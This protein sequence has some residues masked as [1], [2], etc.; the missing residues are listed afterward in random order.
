MTSSVRGSRILAL[1]IALVAAGAFVATLLVRDNEVATPLL[2]GVGAVLFFAS[3]VS[4]LL[5]RKDDAVL[6]DASI[7]YY[8]QRPVVNVVVAVVYSVMVLGALALGVGLLSIGY[9]VGWGLV[10][11]GA[12]G[13]VSLVFEIWVARQPVDDF[14]EE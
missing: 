1:V 3:V 11:C 10:L 2:I 13:L 5:R 9:V 12:A 6:R 7:F 4:V 14:G 8:L